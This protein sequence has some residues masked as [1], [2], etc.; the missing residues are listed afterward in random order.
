[1]Q[2][3]I[4]T[5]DLLNQDLWGVDSANCVLPSPLGDADTQGTAV[6]N[7]LTQ[8]SPVQGEPVSLAGGKV[9]SYPSTCQV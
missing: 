3:L 8:P 9:D 1:M 4:P 6:V 5:P 7:R 2:I